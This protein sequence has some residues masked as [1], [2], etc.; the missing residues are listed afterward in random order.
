MDYQGFVKSLDLPTGY[1]P[2]PGCPAPDAS[3]WPD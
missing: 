3:F 1:T 2:A